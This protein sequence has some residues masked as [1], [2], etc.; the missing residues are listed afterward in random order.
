MHAKTSEEN[1]DAT[2]YLQEKP[3]VATDVNVLLQFPTLPLP[4][5]TPS[6]PHSSKSAPRK[7]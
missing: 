7:L 5:K 2:W 1:I 6:M 4:K 3:T